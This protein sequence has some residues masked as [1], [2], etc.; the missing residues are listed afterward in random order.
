[1]FFSGP[2]NDGSQ[3][4]ADNVVIRHNIL[5]SQ[6]NNGIIRLYS[7]GAKDI[8]IYGNLVFDNGTTGGLS[9]A[10]ATSGTLDLR[11]YNNVFYNTFVDLGG[12]SLNVRTLELKNNIVQYSSSQLRNSGGITSQSNNILTSSN[13][14]FNNPGNKPS[15]FIGTHGV[16]LRPD[17]DGFSL[18]AGSQALNAGTALGSAYSSS[19]NSVARPQGS[20]WEIGAYEIGVAA[21][22]PSTPANLRILP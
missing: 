10:G 17:T 22:T 13:P 15:G 18:T 5:T 14:G 12:H 3:R 4:S 19:I 16:T 21:A 1:V 20:A 7:K 2:E 8:K 11:I 6:D 9:L